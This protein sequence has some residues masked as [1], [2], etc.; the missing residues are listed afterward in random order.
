[1]ETE[2]SIYGYLQVV[3][4]DSEWFYKGIYRV[5]T[6]LD[7]RHGFVGAGERKLGKRVYQTKSRKFN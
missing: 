5:R 3:F 4:V 6:A 2:E 1:M 7:I